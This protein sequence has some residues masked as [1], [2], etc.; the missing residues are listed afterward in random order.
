MFGWVA[1]LPE[2]LLRAIGMS[3]YLGCAV[4]VISRYGEYATVWVVGDYAIKPQWVLE[5]FIYVLILA[6]YAGREKAIERATA[7]HEIVLPLLGAL[8]PFAFLLVDL[9]VTPPAASP[10]FGR[11][12]I[13]A[14]LAGTL[15]TLVSYY[16]LGTS[17][18][19]L[20][21]A[22]ELRSRG[23]Y[24]LVRHPI[25]LGQLITFAGVAAARPCWESYAVY[26]LFL[27]LQVARA[28]IEER[29][30]VRASPGY[31][32]YRERTWMFVPFV[33]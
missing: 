21:D 24:R 13:G 15:L 32:E 14:M 3:F 4:W 9:L 7:D 31:A 33:V 29:K 19:I 12:I 11:P 27:V 18:S 1:R 5:S 25:Y 22:R 26:A 23:P 30:L 16:Y 10:G 8:L 20:A 2:N 28:A 17:F 6:A